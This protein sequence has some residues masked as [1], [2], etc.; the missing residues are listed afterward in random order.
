MTCATSAVTPPRSTVKASS[1]P[2]AESTLAIEWPTG[3][4]RIEENEYTKRSRRVRREARH[5]SSAAKRMICDCSTSE[6][7]R[8]MGLVPCGA[9]CLNRM[10]LIECS[11]RCPCGTFCT[12]RSF[13]RRAIAPIE[14]F[15]TQGKGW[16][17]R[18]RIE[19]KSDMFLVEYVGEV[20]DLREFKRRCEKYSEQ[21]NEHFYFMSLQND[22]FLGKISF[23][24]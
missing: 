18:T 1:L 2:N 7:E 16:G 4:E 6:Q 17:I 14:P 8:A 13:K 11:A 22:L 10:L 3:Y 5:K 12:N 9:D 15:C 23:Y 21:N 19:L 24:F 20:I